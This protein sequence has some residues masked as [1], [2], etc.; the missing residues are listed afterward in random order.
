M[1]TSTTNNGFTIEHYEQADRSTPS[2]TADGTQSIF[3]RLKQI[4]S[5]S[6]ILRV[7]GACAVIASMSLFLLNGWSDGNDIQRY[8]KLLAQTGLLAGSGIALSFWLKE[9]KGARLF[10]GLGLISVVAN[11]T[12]LG[13][14]TYSMVQLDGGLIDYP[15][16]VTWKVVSASTFWP[17]FAGAVT[18]L[19]LLTRFSFSIYARNIAGPLSLNFLIL[20][21]LLLI[22]VRSSLAISIIAIAAVLAAYKAVEQLRKNQHV[23]LTNETKF[24]FCLLF[25][26]GLIIIARA[27]SLYNVDGVLLLTLSGLGYVSIRTLLSKLSDTSKFQP[28][29]EKVQFFVGIFFAFQIIDLLPFTVGIFSNGICN[30]IFSFV[31]MAL[32]F[33]QI[34][35]IKNP[36]RKKTILNLTTAGLVIVNIGMAFIFSNDEF[37]QFSSLATCIA[38]FFAAN[39]QSISV[40]DSHFSRTISVSGIVACSLFLGTHIVTLINLNNWVVIGLI[41]AILIIVGSLYER[42]GLSLRSTKS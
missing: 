29:L 40:S 4:T 16:I 20:C 14:L 7:F 17:V 33:D 30:I 5:V 2:D 32:S 28:V 19:G 22:P 35:R 34:K 41:G 10:L 8:F 15:S 25:V 39:S 1:N 18:L 31:V 27:I 13:A 6:D 23:V 21:S 36:D 38:L 3:D 12:I 9:N 11:F 37:L 42:Y 26:P 24:A